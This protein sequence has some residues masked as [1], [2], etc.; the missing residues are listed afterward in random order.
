MI[1]AGTNVYIAV[2]GTADARAA[3]SDRAVPRRPRRHLPDVPDR[4]AGADPGR[5]SRA[6]SSPSCRRPPGPR[7]IHRRSIA[8]QAEQIL[9]KDPDV[10]GVFAVM[11]FSFSGSAPNQG[12]IFFEPQAVRGA[13]RARSTSCQAVLEPAS[14]AAVRDQRRDRPPVRAAADPRTRRVRR[15]RDAG[16]G[17]RRHRHRRAGERH[18]RPRRRGQPVAAGDAASSARSPSTTRSCRSRSTASGRWR[19]GC[20]SARSRARCRSTWARSTSTTSTSTTA[21]IASTCRPTRRSAPI[22]SGA[23][24]ALRPHPRRADG[25]ARERRPRAGDDGAGGHQPLQP[26]PLG[27]DQ[28]IGGAR[29]Q[30][31]PGAAGNGAPGRRERCR[32]A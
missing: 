29:L 17:P 22:R 8:R 24:A 14:R 30:L 27:G 9:M 3:G 20:R 21:R 26:V 15:L 10:Q 25:A 5:G 12:L 32:R 16:A 19:W 13:R 1:A 28:R 6:T 4:P 31:G 2:A 18:L 23:E 11:G 7:S